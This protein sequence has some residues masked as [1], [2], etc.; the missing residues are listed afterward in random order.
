MGGPGEAEEARIQPSL[1]ILDQQMKCGQ[2]PPPAMGTSRL[3]S[4]LGEA[5]RGQESGDAKVPIRW[6][7]LG[8]AWLRSQVA[9]VTL[10]PGVT[11]HLPCCWQG[12][13]SQNVEED[14]HDT[15]ASMAP[16]SSSGAGGPLPPTSAKIMSLPDGLSTFHTSLLLKDPDL[17]WCS[18]ETK[19]MVS[20]GGLPGAAQAP[21]L[22]HSAPAQS[23]SMCTCSPG[24]S[25]KLQQCF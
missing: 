2:G 25:K 15:L 20:A 10:Q 3:V 21:I 13:G 4:V 22:P 12:S 24:L 18:V 7:R 11:G 19:S 9:G 14:S 5:P 17:G 23:A 6:C 16:G 8:L 1:A